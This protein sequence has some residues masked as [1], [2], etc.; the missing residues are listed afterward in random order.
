M[1]ESAPVTFKNRVL[2]HAPGRLLAVCLAAAAFLQCTDADATRGEEPLD[3]FAAPRLT[4]ESVQT[5]GYADLSDADTPLTPL[6]REYAAGVLG[7]VADVAEGPDSMVYVADRDFQKIVVFSRDGAFDRLI[8]GGYGE[9]PGE[10]IRIRSISV[11]DDGRLA[12]LDEG[13]NR[14]SVFGAD[15]ELDVT[16]GVGAIT[17]LQIAF[18]G[19]TIFV[20]DW[21]G[22]DERAIH[23]FSADGDS[24]GT[25]LDVSSRAAHFSEFGSVGALAQGPAGAALYATPMPGEWRTLRG[26]N[27]ENHGREMFPKINGLTLHD[28]RGALRRM[29]VNTRDIGASQDRTILLA[30]THHPDP[31]DIEVRRSD[32]YVARFTADVELAGLAEISSSLGAVM[33]R[34]VSRLGSEIY[35][36]AT[37]PF[38][39]V[40][41]VRLSEPRTEPEP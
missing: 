20:L 24:L 12:A 7:N 22:T 18:V 28:E 26:R 37:A 2:D 40:K 32:L 38:P 34:E 36:S 17:P 35:V 19:D 10:F 1:R 5:Y 23:T 8:L 16:F 15:D 11:S 31:T 30:F 25:L 6:E 3:V 39:H 13:L 4:V 41:R 29:P 21:Y 33:S 27:V 9:G 14:V